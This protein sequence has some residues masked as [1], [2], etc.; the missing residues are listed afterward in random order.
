MKPI[1]EKERSNLF[2][3]FLLFYVISIVVVLFA[4]FGNIELGRKEKESLNQE[5]IKCN[6]QLLEAQKFFDQMKKLE[7]ILTKVTDPNMQA[8]VKADYDLEKGTA[9]DLIRSNSELASRFGWKDIV[10]GYE[11]RWKDKGEFL[12]QSDMAGSIKTLIGERD[13]WKKKSEDLDEAFRNYRLQH[14]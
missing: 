13:A 10:T 9:L 2:F 8:K 12:G 6:N 7:D 14:P 11:M 5:K 3:Q 1:N 4:A